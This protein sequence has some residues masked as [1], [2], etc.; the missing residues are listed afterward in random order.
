MVFAVSVTTKRTSTP[1]RLMLPGT[2][3]PPM[4]KVRPTGAS[5]AATCDGVK[6]NTRFL[7]NA[8]RTSAV[9]TPSATTPRAIQAMRLCLGFTLALYQHEHFD[10]QEREGNAIGAPDVKRITTHVKEVV[11]RSPKSGTDHV[12]IERLDARRRKTWSVPD[13]RQFRSVRA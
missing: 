13:F 3:M 5:F 2:T 4:R 12:F 10:S 1:S 7:L 9:A 8:V 11:H 6:K